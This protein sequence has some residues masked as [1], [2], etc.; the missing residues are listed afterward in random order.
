MNKNDD[1]IQKE[2]IEETNGTQG[3]DETK[4]PEVI[5]E[6]VIEE[7]EADLPR[8]TENPHHEI[9]WENRYKRALADYQNLEKR[10][11]SQRRELILSASKG[12]LE[13]LLPVLDTLQLAEK[14][15]KDQGLTVSIQ[16]FLDVLKAEGVEKIESVGKKFD[17]VTMEAVGTGEGSDGKVIEEA[18][19]GYMLN[20]ILLRPAQVIVGRKE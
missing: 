6:E 10:V 18:R 19:S 16:Q 20:E 9:E 14:H 13:R 17:P 8:Q 2:E 5:S 1:T 4:E 15:T 12:I 7:Y 11:A 3:T